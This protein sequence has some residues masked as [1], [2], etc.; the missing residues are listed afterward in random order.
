MRWSLILSTVIVTQSALSFAAVQPSLEGLQR[1]ARGA[2]VPSKTYRKSSQE[3]DYAYKFDMNGGV[4]REKLKK[5]ERLP[6]NQKTLLIPKTDADHVF[7][8]QILNQHLEDHNIKFDDLHPKLQEKVKGIINGPKNMAPVPAGVNRGKGQVIKQGLKGKAI[9]PKKDRDEYTKVSY[10]TAAKTA[11]ALDRALKKGGHDFGDDT[12]HK[13]LKDTMINAKLRKPGDPS[14]PSS[15][16]TS[17]TNS[18][19]SSRAGSKAGSKA[20]TP[21]NSRPGTPDSSGAGPSK[22]APK[23]GAKSKKP[24]KV[25]KTPTRKSTRIPALKA[26]KA[27][28]AKNA[29]KKQ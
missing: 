7:E 4:T 25:P 19:D 2:K 18:K 10:G 20:G 13:K 3:H 6:K 23:T 14:P 9:A 11:K 21:A 27:K 5:S 8:H 16:W 15:G 24:V 22:A 29:A 28:A 26:A 12:L 1:R 17:S